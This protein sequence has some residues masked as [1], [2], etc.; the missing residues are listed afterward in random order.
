MCYNV[1]HLH[2]IITPMD[3]DTTIIIRVDKD[4]KNKLQTLADKDNRSLSDYIRLQLKKL[5]EKTK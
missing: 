3:K 1:L 2:R 4:L 5:T